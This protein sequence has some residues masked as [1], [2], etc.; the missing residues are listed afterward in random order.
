MSKTCLECGEPLIGRADKKFCNDQCRSTH[1]Q[2]SQ[3][4]VTPLVKSVNNI[5]KKNRLILTKLNPDGKAKVKKSTL[6][7]E[8]FQ[9]KYFTNTYT[10]RDNRV[11]YFVYDHGYLPLENEYFALVINKEI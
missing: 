5:L 7:K 11:Y 6:E 2:K 8:G 1:Y 10:T 4:D 3:A 9:F